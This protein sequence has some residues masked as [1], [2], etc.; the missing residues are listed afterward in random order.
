MIRFSRRVSLARRPGRLLA[1]ALTS[2]L[3]T[4]TMHTG[5]ASARA[6][7]KPTI[8]FV[9]GA[10][11]DAS[12][13]AKVTGRLQDRGYTVIS[14]ANPLRGL[15]SDSAYVASVI[16]T[17]EGPIVL[18]GHSY[19]GAVIS[20]VANAVPNVKALVYINGNALDAGES[21][22]DI[23]Q[24]F[25]GG[26]LGPALRPRAFRQ[27]DGTLGTE[28]YIDPA[29]F[30][31]V[32]AADL[33]ARTVAT[34]ATAQRPVTQA[35]LEEEAATPAWKTLPTWYLVGTKDETIDPAAQRFMAKRAEAHTVKVASSHA[36]YLSH[37]KKVTSLILRAARHVRR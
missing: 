6:G 9:H 25:T 16:E 1:A 28:F 34:M 35:A 8:V 17:V 36:S 10:F 29:S 33:P 20:P 22:L 26:K 19:G 24:R 5:I 2:L 23:A 15:A 3:L 30:R 31:A 14:P 37:P 18:V 13:F 11:A 7:D 12:G 4:I 21:A 32:F 27:P